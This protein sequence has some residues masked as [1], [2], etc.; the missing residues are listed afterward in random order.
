MAIDIAAWCEKYA[1]MIIRRCRALLRN[2]D[3]AM[4]AV[5]DVFMNLIRAK[6]RLKGS[7]PSSL[8]YVTATN[9]CLNRLRSRRREGEFTP[10]MEDFFSA[11]ERGYEQADAELL[12]KAILED[13]S[14]KARTICFM[15]YADG[16]TLSEIGEAIGLSISGVRKRLIAFRKRAR[17]KLGDDI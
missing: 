4:D 9:V 13:E 17:L 12:V 2:D 14:E 6:R 5:Q 1:P 11:N 3:D 16:M 10:G 8:L 7:F 15:Y